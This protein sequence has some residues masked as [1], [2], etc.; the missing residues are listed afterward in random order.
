MEEE[1]KL[2]ARDYDNASSN[3]QSLLADKSKADLTAKMNLQQQGERMFPLNPASM[4]DEPSF[5]NRPLF[6]GGG[7]GAGLVLGLVLALW[8][9]LRD[10]SIRT[11][12][13]AEAAT[14]LPL[15]VAVPWVVKAEAGDNGNSSWSRNKRQP[16]EDKETIGA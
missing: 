15:L 14:E 2:L 12:A 10:N 1:Y 4:P 8:L 3:Y 11:E 5:P 13:D 9:E 7:L 16:D 6:V